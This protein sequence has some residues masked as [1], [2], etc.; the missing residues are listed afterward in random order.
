[1]PIKQRRVKRTNQPDWIS[2]ESIKTRDRHNSLGN[3]DK[4]KLWR[5]KVISMI[6]TAKRDQYQSYI[7]NSKGKPGSIYK[8]F[9]EVGAGKGLRKQSTIGSN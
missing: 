4:Y 8:I 6:K 2:P 1:M 7:E 3:S 9:Q 5:N